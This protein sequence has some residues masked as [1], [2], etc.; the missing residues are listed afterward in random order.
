MGF[1]DQT[2]IYDRNLRLPFYFFFSFFMFASC[3][4]GGWG[5]GHGSGCSTREPDP[6]PN[7]SSALFGSSSWVWSVLLSATFRLLR[8]I[9]Q[10]GSKVSPVE[11]ALPGPGS[12]IPSEMSGEC[13]Y[14]LLFAQNQSRSSG[15]TVWNVEM[16]R[17][18]RS[19]ARTM[20]SMSMELLDGYNVGNSIG[21]GSNKCV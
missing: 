19:I 21:S 1:Y 17:E 15:G 8:N 9:S 20:Y 16:S 2:F 11:C 13:C 12:S 10:V 3:L 7:L 14:R 18:F 5:S 6:D 4:W